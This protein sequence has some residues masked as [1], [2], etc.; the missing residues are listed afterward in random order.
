MIVG[1]DASAPG[2]V[3]VRDAATGRWFQFT[4]PREIVTAFTVADV[5]SGLER[6]ENAVAQR[7]LYAAGFISY[8]VA[9][10]F[11]PGLTVKGSAGFPLLWFGLYDGAE[12]V[13]LPAHSG[14]TAGVRP[15]SG[16]ATSE[17]SIVSGRS[18]VLGGAITAAPDRKSTRLNS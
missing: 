18:G 2:R 16:A 5:A 8:E 15:S 7:G 11:D 6:V 10:A 17:D 1:I 14:R 9:P 12:P 3:L 4:H 13:D